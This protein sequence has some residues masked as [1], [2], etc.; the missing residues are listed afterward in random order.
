MQDWN[1]GLLIILLIPFVEFMKSTISS[2]GGGSNSGDKCPFVRSCWSPW[3]IYYRHS[4]PICWVNGQGSEIGVSR[5]QR[6][7]RSQGS[8]TYKQLISKVRFAIMNTNHLS[9]SPK[10]LTAGRG[11]EERDLSQASEDES[12][13]LW[14]WVPLFKDITGPPSILEAL[15]VWR[16]SSAGFSFSGSSLHVKSPKEFRGLPLYLHPLLRWSRN[17]LLHLLSLSFPLTC[18]C[19]FSTSLLGPLIDLSKLVCSK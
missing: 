10:A 9:S 5:A 16:V 17:K 15:C 11:K 2:G 4:V 1:P 12:W 7:N 19:N 3:S 13:W 14:G 18:I 8:Q 6:R